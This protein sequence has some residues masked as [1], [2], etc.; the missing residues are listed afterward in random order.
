VCLN[1]LSCIL[2]QE[3]LFWSEYTECLQETMGAIAQPGPRKSFRTQCS[4]CYRSSCVPYRGVPLED[5]REDKLE[6]NRYEPA[7]ATAGARNSALDAMY[8]YIIS[9]YMFVCALRAQNRALVFVMVAHKA[10]RHA[11]QPCTR[12]STTAPAPGLQRPK[13][14]RTDPSRAILIGQGALPCTRCK[15]LRET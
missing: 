2:G 3:A 8:T 12:I 14:I 5:E 7:S 15:N 1:L 10:A 4:T 6:E 11:R 9:S 13:S